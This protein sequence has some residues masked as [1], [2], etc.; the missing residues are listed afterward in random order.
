MAKGKRNGKC[1]G[2]SK[3]QSGKHELHRRFS[4]VTNSAKR[5]IYLATIMGS[6]SCLVSFAVNLL[7][8][9][10]DSGR[11]RVGALELTL[12]ASAAFSLYRTRS[13]RKIFACG[14]SSGNEDKDG[15]GERLRDETS[16]PRAVEIHELENTT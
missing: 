13:R 4:R 5:A 11:V 12:S 7:L 16:S 14:A 10:A 9:N 15:A 1:C 6:S 2:R 3:A 8:M